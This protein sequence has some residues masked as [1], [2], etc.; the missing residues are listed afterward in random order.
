MTKFL[1]ICM[2]MFTSTS[3]WPAS[4]QPVKLTPELL[5]Q[6]QD[7]LTGQ[8]VEVE[9]CVY[10]HHH[11]RQIGPCGDHSWRQ[12]VSVTD[13][14]GLI[15]KALKSIGKLPFVYGSF[16]AVF[17][18]RIVTQEYTWPQQGKRPALQLIHVSNFRE[19]GS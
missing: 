9:A 1:A 6:K 2:L 12:I 3:A 10:L 13:P 7:H 11:G 15:P 18:G 17:R 4:E 19:H 5:A 14:D 8:I 16:K